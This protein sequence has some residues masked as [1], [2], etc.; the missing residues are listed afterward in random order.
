MNILSGSCELSNDPRV[1]SWGS[2]LLSCMCCE[3]EMRK[4]DFAEWPER[5][6]DGLE[7]HAEGNTDGDLKSSSI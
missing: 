1:K 3:V 5:S 2:S 7:G 6:S 4:L